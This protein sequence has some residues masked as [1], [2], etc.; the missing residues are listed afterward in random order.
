MKHVHPAFQKMYETGII[1]AVVIHDENDAPALAKAMIDGGIPVAEVTFRTP[2]AAKAI[3]KMKE[4]CPEMLVGAGTILTVD[5]AALAIQAGAEFLVAPGLNPE[6]VQFAAKNHIP[7]IP[8]V[9]TASEIETALNLGLQICKFFPAEPYGGLKTIKAF[10]GPYKTMTYLPT[11]GIN[12]S[13]MNEYLHSDLVFA[14]G[15]TWMVPQ[16]LIQNHKF[17]EI[18]Q[19]CHE[20]VVK[21]L[22][23]HLVHFAVNACQETALKDAQ[24]LADLFQTNVRKIDA[25]YFAGDIVEILGKVKIGTYGHIAI[26]TPNVERAMAFYTHKGYRFDASSIKTNQDG[27]ITLVYFQDEIAG[28]KFHLIQD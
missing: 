19:L 12:L 24:A 6:V 22:D 5:Q 14:V 15:G 18:Q 8:G 7:M 21:M 26:G 10:G 9:S 4:T 16:A 11:G 17:D 2:A 20:A 27:K 25:G 23:L 3:S 28:F 1:P 13:N